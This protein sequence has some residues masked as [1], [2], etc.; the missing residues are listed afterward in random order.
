MLRIDKDT[1]YLVCDG[2][3]VKSDIKHQLTTRYISQHNGMTERKNR[4]MMDMVRS[5]IHSKCI[6]KFI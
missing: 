2:Y 3:E 6:L 5:M 4:T 1:E